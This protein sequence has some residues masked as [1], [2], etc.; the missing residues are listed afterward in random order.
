MIQNIKFVLIIILFTILP[1]VLISKD[2]TETNYYKKIRLGESIHI[3]NT[4]S[5][6]SNY[7]VGINP[8]KSSIFFHEKGGDINDGV[9]PKIIISD[10]LKK[11]KY[12][13]SNGQNIKIFT[14]NEAYKIKL[15]PKK[16]AKD[17]LFMQ[18]NMAF[19]KKKKQSKG[20][21]GP[22]MRKDN[23]YYEVTWCGD[24][25]KDNYTTDSG[26]LINEECDP[27]D[28]T[29][30][31]WNGNLCSTECKIVQIPNICN[32]NTYR[33]LRYGKS[34][35]FFEGFKNK[36]NNT[37]KIQGVRYNFDERKGGD[38][39]GG[40][41]PKFSFTSSLNEKN[42]KINAKEEQK[43]YIATSS[44]P[45]TYHPKLRRKDNLFIKYTVVYYLIKDSKNQGP[46]FNV[47]CDYNEVTWCGDG[48]RD[49][50]IEKSGIK[51]YEE[52]D[53]GNI[54]SGDGCSSSCQLEK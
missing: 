35:T 37:I 13:I 4:F 17:N 8:K 7:L 36:S 22:Y 52:C 15:H 32:D 16:R 41:S 51:I 30:E 11:V 5:N 6:K 24:G 34:Y 29:K 25:I 10:E 1:Q 2:I 49:N 38:L 44:Y 43:I 12:K 46:F 27:M 53:D 9:N 18:Y 19:H 40:E 14:T 23:L 31:N 20:W 42:M 48:V 47:H 45:I 50:Y 54:E 28:K 26:K 39:N 21:W 33:K 3:N